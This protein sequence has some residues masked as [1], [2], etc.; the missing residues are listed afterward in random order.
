MAKRRK[1]TGGRSAGTPNKATAAV[2]ETLAEAFEQI[3]GVAALVVWAKRNDDNRACFYRIWSRS[4][5]LDVT[6]STK[7]EDLVNGSLR[8]RS[9]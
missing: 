6:L 7:L 2:K 8:S 1:K 9:E 5:P 4:A 3:G